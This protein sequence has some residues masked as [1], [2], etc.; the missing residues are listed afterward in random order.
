MVQ[1]SGVP[2]LRRFCHKITADAQLLEAKHFLR[3]KLSSLLSSME[4][5][6][7]DSTV[8][9]QGDEDSAKE[10]IYDAHLSAK[11]E[12]RAILNPNI[13]RLI[14]KGDLRHREVQKALQ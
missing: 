6:S 7:H 3:S 4:I 10:V 13:L 5:W 12:V 2:E 8:D 11:T 1:A 14:N 9:P